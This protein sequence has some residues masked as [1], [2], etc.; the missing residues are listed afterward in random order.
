[1]ACGSNPHPRHISTYL[2]AFFALPVKRQSG[3]HLTH[4]EVINKLDDETVSYEIGLGVA[5][6][7]AENLRISIKVESAAYETA[8]AWLKDLIYGSEFDKER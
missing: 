8:I 3:E 4:E 1:M 7:F 2:S 5:N 6:S